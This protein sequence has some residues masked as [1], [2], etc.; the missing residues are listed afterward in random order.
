[1]KLITLKTPPATNDL[2]EVLK[3]EFSDRYTY[4]V[5]GLGSEKTI[6]VQKSFFI[7]AQISK[8]DKEFTIYGIQPT[9]SSTL[10]A[11]ALQVLANSYILFSPSAYRKLEKEIGLFLR[12]KYS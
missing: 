4:Q 12:T 8:R 3:K 9:I 6:I 2:I 11:L 7:G 5:F 1:M 10:I